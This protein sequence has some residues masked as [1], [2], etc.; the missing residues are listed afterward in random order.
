MHLQAQSNNARCFNTQPRG[1]GCVRDKARML[2]PVLFQ[3]TAARRRLQIKGTEP[4]GSV[5]V[6]THSRAEAAAY[7]FVNIYD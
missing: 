4:N 6:S 2:A 1:G 7:C 5:Y 3:H